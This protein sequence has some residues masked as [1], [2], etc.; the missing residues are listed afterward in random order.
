MIGIIGAMAEEVAWLRA[1][2]TD[3]MEE[4]FGI[5][6]LYTGTLFGHKTVL[7]RCGIGKVHAALCAQA[8]IVRCRPEWVLNIGVAGA[9][10]EGLDIGHIV[11]GDYAVQYDIDTTA[12]GDPMGCVP[13]INQVQLPCD[14]TL[15]DRL[16]AA[17]E[18]QKLP[19]V[20]AG[21][22]TGDR[23]VADVA[24]KEALDRAF[25]AAACDMEGGAIAQV[26]VEMNSPY[27]AYRVISD[28][29]RGNEQDYEKNVAA[30]GLSSQRLL[31]A[32]LAGSV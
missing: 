11:V 9:L 8:M 24:S 12:F 22:A 15:S 5:A 16:C 28:T 2:M 31:R 18:T 32:L 19:F 7:S 1:Q 26:C 27:A 3:V 21:I 17:C 23:F 14:R 13:E 30:A 4:T 6:T 10:R 25:G 20:R 29:L